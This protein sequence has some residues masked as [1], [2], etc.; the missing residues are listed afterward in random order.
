MMVIAKLKWTF[1]LLFF[2]IFIIAPNAQANTKW[3]ILWNDDDSLMETV[4]TDEQVSFQPN[5]WQLSVKEGKASYHREIKDWQEYAQLGDRLPLAV[6]VKDYLLFKSIAFKAQAFDP[7]D[8]TLAGFVG[9]GPL[10]ISISVPG[11]IRSGSA[12]EVKD[13]TAVWHLN[14]LTDLHS[15]GNMLLVDTFDGF[16]LGL[17]L[18][19]LG[20]VIIGLTY[21][22]RVRRTHKLIEQEYSLENLTL[23][24][25]QS[26]ENK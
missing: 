7:Q 5:G 10:D 20:I 18:I 11:L 13:L 16:L 24:T 25:E 19:L 15:R 22:S 9:T 23:P 14:N 2:L 21:L 6:S 17:L 12:D 26:K 1:I 3:E 4:A 8:D